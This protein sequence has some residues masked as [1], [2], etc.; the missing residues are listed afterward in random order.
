MTA[1]DVTVRS[2]WLDFQALLRA[3]TYRNVPK[4]SDRQVWA[5]SVDPDQTQDLHFLSFCLHL[6]DQLICNKTM[7]FQFY[8]NYRNVLDVRIFR[9]FTAQIIL[10]LGSAVAQW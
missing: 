8:C 4:F 9:I 5:N 2:E 3:L 7:V 1:V 6:L 10:K